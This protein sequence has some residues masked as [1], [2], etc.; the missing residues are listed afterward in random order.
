[1]TVNPAR[2]FSPGE[3]EFRR[4]VDHEHLTDGTAALGTRLHMR[5]QHGL[6]RDAPIPQEPIEPLRRT[7]IT[8]RFGKPPVRMLREGLRT[9]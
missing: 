6:E 1:M 2:A 3:V 7:V 8:T 4:V 5:R 9:T